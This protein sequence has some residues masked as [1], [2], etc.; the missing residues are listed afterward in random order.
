MR[1]LRVRYAPVAR[2]ASSLSSRLLVLQPDV[3]QSG[4]PGN[5]V[6]PEQSLV[7][8][9]TYRIVKRRGV[10]ADHKHDHADVFVGHE[11]NL[12]MK[13]RQVA[14]VKRDEMTA[15]GRRPASHA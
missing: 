13:T 3:E 12:G 15:I 14:A 11:G 6:Y 4:G 10:I 5:L 1:W 2:F 7:H 9:I 8:V